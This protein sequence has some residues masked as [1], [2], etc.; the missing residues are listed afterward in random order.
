MRSP[1]SE[2]VPTG[3][4]PDHA[5]TNGV[6]SSK[7]Q[8]VSYRTI[9]GNEQG[10]E[11]PTFSV[12]ITIEVPTGGSFLFILAPSHAIGDLMAR[13]LIAALLSG[14]LAWWL[15][16]PIARQPPRG[17]AATTPQAAGQG[18]GAKVVPFGGAFKSSEACEARRQAL[19]KDPVVGRQMAKGWCVFS[20]APGMQ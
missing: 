19:L 7:S 4:S 12:A 14:Y 8:W 11:R 5:L 1:P 9:R 10:T 2:S 13:S 15:M 17:A 6:L 16:I 3:V 20:T 18:E